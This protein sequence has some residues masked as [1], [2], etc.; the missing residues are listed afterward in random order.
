VPI[1]L[2]VSQSEPARRKGAASSGQLLPGYNIITNI[3][4]ELSM[5]IGGTQKPC[6]QKGRKLLGLPSQTNFPQRV[7]MMKCR[8]FASYV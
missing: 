7:T 3:F 1:F 6:P 5:D 4:R 2:I 8:T